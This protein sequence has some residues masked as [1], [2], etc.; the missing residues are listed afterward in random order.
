M[1]LVKVSEGAS[2]ALHGMALIARKKSQ[3]LTVKKIAQTLNVSQ[4]HLAKVFQQLQ[5]SGL[6]HSV[7]GPAGGFE[8]KKNPEDITFLDILQVI[9]GKIELGGCPFNK[10]YCAFDKCIFSNELNRLTKEIYDTFKNMRL[11]DFV[12]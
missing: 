1:S 11:S 3:R 5:K 8:L 2:I 6:V 12:R 7:R 9:E 4:T 10:D